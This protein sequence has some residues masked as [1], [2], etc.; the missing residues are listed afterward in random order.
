MWELTEQLAQFV[1]T[2]FG[3]RPPHTIKIVI[4]QW[5]AL[6]TPDIDLWSPTCVPTGMCSCTLTGM[7][8]LT[9]TQVCAVAHTGTLYTARTH[10]NKQIN[11]QYW[12]LKAQKPYLFFPWTISQGWLATATWFWNLNG[13]T[14][15]SLLLPLTHTIRSHGLSSAVPFKH[16]SCISL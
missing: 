10:T 14:Q 9:H 5:R 16:Q 3:E 11:K 1:G 12:F 15:A 8:S 2:R 4:T 13:L 7:C 6:T